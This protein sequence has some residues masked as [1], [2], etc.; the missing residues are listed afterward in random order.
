MEFLP[1]VYDLF[2]ISNKFGDNK[3]PAKVVLLQELEIFN[4]LISK[5]FQSLDDLIKAINGEIGMSADIE[6]VLDALFNGFLPQV[7]RSKA[8]QTKK[9]LSNWI[10]FFK[11]RNTQ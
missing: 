8:P 3:S 9:A 10:N 11:A 6:N 7:W 4:I 1:E 5:M 2:N